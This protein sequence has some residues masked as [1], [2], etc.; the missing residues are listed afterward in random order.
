MTIIL[1]FVLSNMHSATNFETDI[2][3]TRIGCCWTLRMNDVT[4]EE[5]DDHR[6]TCTLERAIGDSLIFE[7]N[8]GM[9]NI[10][11]RMERD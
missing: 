4:G 7:I 11:E 1:I 8:Q 6:A 9:S 10:F 5:E 2:M 3:R